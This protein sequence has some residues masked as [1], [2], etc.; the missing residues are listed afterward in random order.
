MNRKAK[1]L[2]VSAGFALVFVP[3]SATWESGTQARVS[4]TYGRLPLRFEAN[5]GQTDPQVKFISRGDRH[6][7]FLTSPEAV[8]AFTAPRSSRGEGRPTVLRMRFVGANPEPRVSGLEELPGKAN[9]F[10]GNDPAR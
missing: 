8:L 6:V 1:L 7:L 4:E 3:S 5:R 10:I 2:V 9:Y